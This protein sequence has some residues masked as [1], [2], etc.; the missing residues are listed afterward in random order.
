M[1]ILWC[2]FVLPKIRENKMTCIDRRSE[3]TKEIVKE[4]VKGTTIFVSFLPV[5]WESKK[6]ARAVQSCLLE[7]EKC[8]ILLSARLTQDGTLLS[9]SNR[10]PRQLPGS[11]VAIP[12]CLCGEV[13][14]EPC[15]GLLK[16]SAGV[17]MRILF[18]A[19]TFEEKAANRLW[20]NIVRLSLLAPF[21][22]YIPLY[23]QNDI[24]SHWEVL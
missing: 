18:Y 22:V 4:G 16:N 23:S 15:C 10:G 12:P 7:C 24:C 9:T 13:L 19:I 11:A 1:S 6:S 5:P 3:M 2:D 20:P 14:D 8:C 21:Q 17:K